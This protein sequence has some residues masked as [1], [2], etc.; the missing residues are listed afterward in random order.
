MRSMR[1]RDTR[2]FVAHWQAWRGIFS[3]PLIGG[4]GVAEMGR[5]VEFRTDLTAGLKGES[6]RPSSLRFGSHKLTVH[7][8][9]SC[10]TGKNQRRRECH[11]NEE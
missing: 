10:V 11:E 8:A 6:G 5:M 1:G 2:K 7:D 3:S 4:G 9:S